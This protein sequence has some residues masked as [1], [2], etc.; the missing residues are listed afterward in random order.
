MASR[1]RTIRRGYAKGHVENART[2]VFDDGSDVFCRQFCD[3][4][5]RASRPNICARWLSWD[6]VGVDGRC[7][8]DGN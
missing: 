2:G 1:N 3:Q 8:R 7:A 6:D 5:A 4:Y